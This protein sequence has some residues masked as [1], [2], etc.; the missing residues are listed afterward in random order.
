MHPL[1]PSTLPANLLRILLLSLFASLISSVPSEDRP[2]GIN[3]QG[4]S[5]CSFSNIDTPN[6]LYKFNTTA[7]FGVYAPVDDVLPGGPIRDRELWFSGEHIICAENNNHLIGSFCLFLQGD[8][9]P[10]NGV[11]GSILR[12]R[13]GAGEQ[14]AV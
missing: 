5:Q 14:P 11:P 12:E 3:C 6:L 13:A 1:T 2:F 9:V 4:S 10:K 7:S 8:Y